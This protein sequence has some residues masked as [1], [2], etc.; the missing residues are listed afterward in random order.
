MHLLR[1]RGVPR[2][3]KSLWCS[4][5]PPRGIPAQPARTPPFGL[6]FEFGPCSRVSLE[7]DSGFSRVS[8]ALGGVGR[9]PQGPPHP[10]H[11]GKD[12][13]NLPRRTSQKLQRNRSHRPAIRSR[14]PTKATNTSLLTPERP[15]CLPMPSARQNC[16]PR[17]HTGFPIFDSWGTNR[18]SIPLA[19]RIGKTLSHLG[20][21]LPSMHLSDL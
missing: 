18:Q 3:R 15:T 21:A 14:R 13:Q 6:V 20:S 11:L 10:M 1:W 9:G 19:D 5:F 12:P 16:L 8:H 7:D 17:R 2:V 4:S